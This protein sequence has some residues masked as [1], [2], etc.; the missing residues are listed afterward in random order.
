MHDKFSQR[1]E[2][3]LQRHGCA[4]GSCEEACR[5]GSCEP[6]DWPHPAAKPA[7]RRT[8][9][10]HAGAGWL[11]RGFPPWRHLQR[12]LR[13][14]GR[15]LGGR[16]SVAFEYRRLERST[17]LEGLYPADAGRSRFPHPEGPT[18]P[19][20]DLAPARG[21]RAGTYPRLLS[22]LR[23]VEE[24]RDVAE[25]RWSRQFPKNRARRARAHS[26]E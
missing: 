13:P 23:T 8:L 25:P 9:R 24:P 3:A 11:S 15:D 16:L 12:R 18:Q 10:N 5:S 2:E 14:L 26:V 20:S 6:A 4:L 22:R 19:S 17:A 21:S 1:I 7:I